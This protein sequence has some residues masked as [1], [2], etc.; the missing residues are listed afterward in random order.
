MIL[1]HSDGAHVYYY[2]FKLL[3]NLLKKPFIWSNGHLPKIFFPFILCRS[4][5]K[6]NQI[7]I[8]LIKLST[9]LDLNKK[10]LLFGLC[11]GGVPRQMHE[12]VKGLVIHS[13]TK[14]IKMSSLPKVLCLV[15]LYTKMTKKSCFLVWNE[16][17]NPQL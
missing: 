11:Q 7:R 13:E 16:L 17:K 15:I 4:H 8:K 10:R 3:G 14:W 12:I 9:K 1:V 5:K 2:I 6:K